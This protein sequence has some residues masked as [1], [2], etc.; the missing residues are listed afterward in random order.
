MTIRHQMIQLQWVRLFTVLSNS[1]RGKRHRLKSRKFH[2]RMRNNFC[3]LR[4]TEHW[5]GLPGEAVESSSGGSQ[6]PS[7]RDPV[8]LAVGEPAL[9]GVW[10]SRDPFQP[11]PFHGPVIDS[12]TVKTMKTHS[13]RKV[14]AAGA[15]GSDSLT[16]VNL[17][18]KF[19]SI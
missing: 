16:K 2:L 9:A 10:R 6:N 5:N 18:G 15:V 8:Q 12:S 4:M 1:T 14:K 3:P 11:W 17:N 19:C 7:G 13:C